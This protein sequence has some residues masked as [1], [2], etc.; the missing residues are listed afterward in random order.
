MPKWIKGQSGNLKGRPKNP[1]AIAELA[2]SQV[3][4]H[5][6]I[7]KLGSIAAHEQTIVLTAV[8]LNL[9]TAIDV[10]FRAAK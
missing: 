8:S 5:K 9:K 6:L 3:E 2:R 10:A 1:T 7:E 4:K